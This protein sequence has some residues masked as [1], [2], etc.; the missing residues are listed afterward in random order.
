M[1]EVR[2][3][4]CCGS[5]GLRSIK[6]KLKFLI[7]IGSPG[8]KKCSNFINITPILHKKSLDRYAFLSLRNYSRE[9]DLNPTF[10]KTNSFKPHNVMLV[11][12]VN[13]PR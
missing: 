10:D 1:A 6:I 12:T 13:H 4:E 2:F 9:T 11:P 5:Y 8:L 7:A 3:F